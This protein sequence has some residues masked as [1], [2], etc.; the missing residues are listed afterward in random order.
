LEAQDDKGRTWSAGTGF[1]AD[2]RPEVIIREN[3]TVRL[4]AYG[5]PLRVEPTV[6]RGDDP[7]SIE[8]GLEIFG[9]GGEKYSWPRNNSRHS[10]PGIE[11][12][13][14]SDRLLLSAALEYG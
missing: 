4:P 1:P 11:V 5:P 13:D 10:K 14:E 6:A 2:Q 12:R 9:S 8:I 7:G 3:E